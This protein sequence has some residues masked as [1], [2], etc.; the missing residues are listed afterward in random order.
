MIRTADRTTW[1]A[2]FSSR[3][4]SRRRPLRQDAAEELCAVFGQAYAQ[5]SCGDIAQRYEHVLPHRP[6]RVDTARRSTYRRL[7]AVAKGDA[8]SANDGCG[9]SRRC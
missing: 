5:A 4:R 9:R 2:R 7:L 8:G 6:N 3:F 1:P